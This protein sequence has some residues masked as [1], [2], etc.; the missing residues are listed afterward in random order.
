MS[1]ERRAGN[2]CHIRGG[3]L[4]MESQLK[5]GRLGTAF[6]RRAPL[7]GALALCA[8]AAAALAGCGGGSDASAADSVVQSG[9]VPPMTNTNGTPLTELAGFI[10][11]YGTSPTSM[12]Q[13]INVASPTTTSYTISNLTS[14]TWYFT[15]IVYSSAGTQSAPSDV[16]SKTIS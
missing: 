13:T 15:V 1:M 11:N 5:R 14:G 2:A 12:T 9:P 8:L 7:V 3:D 4:D 16:A 10:I 6:G